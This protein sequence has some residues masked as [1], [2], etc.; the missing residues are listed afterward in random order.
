M[1]LFVRRS[2]QGSDCIIDVQLLRLPDLHTT[3]EFLVL[4]PGRMPR[5]RTHDKTWQLSQT[6]DLLSVACR[7]LHA[8]PMLACA[9][10]GFRNHRAYV[11][12]SSASLGTGASASELGMRMM[13]CQS[14]PVGMRVDLKRSALLI[15][16]TFCRMDVM[17]CCLL[18]LPLQF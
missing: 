15:S 12:L 16:T 10:V 4:I 17:W 5:D 7:Y 9:L 13:P 14:M 1:E 2:L 18:L 3:I 6:C 11:C 8:Q